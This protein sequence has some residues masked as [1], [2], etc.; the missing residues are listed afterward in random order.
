MEPFTESMIK[1]GYVKLAMGS[2]RIWVSK[3]WHEMFVRRGL[4]RK[5]FYG[6]FCPNTGSLPEFIRW[7]SLYDK[8]I[9]DRD[10]PRSNPM[11]TPEE[12][13]EIRQVVT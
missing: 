13:V 7:L 12:L 9:H 1:K 10:Y 11:L 8:L 4:V 6:Q 5:N 3:K 2:Y